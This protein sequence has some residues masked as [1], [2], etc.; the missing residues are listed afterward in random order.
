MPNPIRFETC[1]VALESGG[2]NVDP[3]PTVGANAVRTSA[4]LWTGCVPGARWLNKRDDVMNNS[5]IRLA[6]ATAHGQTAA[7]QIQLELKGRGSAYTAVTV[8][9]DWDPLIQA[10]AWTPAWASSPSDQLTY[11]PIGNAARPSCTVYGWA[12]GNLYKVTGCRGNWRM[13]FR[14]GQR[15]SFTFTLEGFLESLPAQTAVPGGSAWTTV[16]PPPA[17]NMSVTLGGWTPQ[18]SELMLESGNT[19][20]WLESGNGTDGLDQYDISMQDPRGTISGRSVSASTFDPFTQLVS[21]P[22]GS[23]A[24][25]LSWGS[26]QY[27]RGQFSDSATF[28]AA[29]PRHV[30][31]KGFTAWTVAFGLV[32]PAALVN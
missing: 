3:V 10:C 7:V 27:N 13:L 26:V 24:F 22:P 29:A 2:Y 23:L 17:V 30:N 32:A 8:G 12:G 15:I 5:L 16:I 18:F 20:D 4:R 21:S 6:P 9:A 1:A 31:E 11:T 19:C 28:I 25:A 14:P